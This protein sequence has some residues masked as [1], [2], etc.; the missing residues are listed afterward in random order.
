M[1]APISISALASE[2]VT[3]YSGELSANPVV[4]IEK[5]SSPPPVIEAAA[6]TTED[7]EGEEKQND[8]G[9]LRTQL[10]LSKL[11]YSA[12]HDRFK[13]LQQ[14][15]S[16]LQ[17]LASAYREVIRG[18]SSV[19]DPTTPIDQLQVEAGRDGLRAKALE[20]DVFRPLVREAGGLQALITQTNTMRTLITKA[21]GLRELEHFV[22]DLR[23]IRDTLDEFKGSQGLV[24][25]ASE[26][27]DL[28]TKKQICTELQSEVHGANGL[29]AKAAKYEKLV[30]AFNEVQSDTSFQRSTSNSTAMNPARAQMISATPLEA[31]PDRDLYEAPPPVEKPNNKT[32]SNNIPLGTPQVQSSSKRRKSESAAASIPEKRLRVELKQASALMQ[33]SLPAAINKSAIGGSCQSNVAMTQADI[34][35]FNSHAWSSLIQGENNL[36]GLVGSQPRTQTAAAPP[37]RTGRM[38]P[39]TRYADVGYL[40]TS[41]MPKYSSTLPDQDTQPHLDAKSDPVPFAARV[42]IQPPL[43]L[44][45]QPGSGAY[46]ALRPAAASVAPIDPRYN[47]VGASNT[48][49]AW[50]AYQS[51]GLKKGFQIPG[52]LVATFV[53]ELSSRIPIAKY[54]AYE[55]MAPNHDTCIL[56]YMIDGHRPSGVAQ[57]RI[58][59]TLCTYQRRPCALL[60]DINGVRTIV[61]LPLRPDLRHGETWSKKTYWVQELQPKE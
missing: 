45:D 22:S 17:D 38:R 19:H 41:G 8:N 56:R 50:D 14:Q 11:E 6:S 20:A 42:S 10:Q 13:K 32:G 58:A 27:R 35:A 2:R 24:G 5:R 51:Y 49:A 37:K 34:A 47:Q 4:K 16:E 52:D 15:H 40:S 44:P 29:R 30:R 1:A 36:T 60:Q 39:D 43:F 12:L 57:D 55:A 18:S 25:L 54:S 48:S 59:C 3:G 31:D 9:F 26:V 28:L 61:F 46:M 21:G 53:A 7:Q 23:T 33:A